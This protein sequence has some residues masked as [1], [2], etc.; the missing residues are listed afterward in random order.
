[1]NKNFYH[2]LSIP[3]NNDY[4]RLIDE[5]FR[6][7]STTRFQ[8]VLDREFLGKSYNLSTIKNL[9]PTIKVLTIVINPW[10]RF[11]RLFKS[12]KTSF[13]INA[14]IYLIHKNKD[15]NLRKTQFDLMFSN[16]E[17][18]ILDFYLRSEFIESDFET[19]KNSINSDDYPINFKTFNFNHKHLFNKQSQDIIREMYQKDFEYFNYIDFL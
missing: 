2:L 5:W 16:G 19:F 14:F 11:Y 9:Y 4:S 3:E 17:C 10:T 13:E 1:M 8:Y 6:N 12:V 18:E 15:S 7:N